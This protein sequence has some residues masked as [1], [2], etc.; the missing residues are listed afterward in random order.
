MTEAASILLLGESGVGKTHYGAQLLKRLMLSDG[1]LRMHGQATNLEPF[2][3]ALDSLSEGRAAGHT[4]TATYLDSVWPV[5][6]SQGHA[7]ELVWPDYGGEQIKALIDSRCVPAAWQVR[8]ASAD[9]WLLLI[10]LQ[11]TRSGDDIFS[12]PLADLRGAS[13]ENK[14][15]QMSDQARLIELLQ[16]LSYAGG[17]SAT[18]IA[19]RPRFAVLLTCW[20]EL[21]L[22]GTPVSALGAHLPM[23][24]DYIRSN[25]SEPCVM[26]LSALG[27]PLSSTERDDDY[28]SRGPEH[29]GYV[30]GPDGSRSSDLTLPISLVING[31]S[32]AGSRT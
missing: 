30:I 16:M 15:V 25:W 17:I 28:V 9:A 27:R 13:I 26:A 4:A 12:R 22:T 10:R 32:T 23:L 29:F 1:H 31:P 19:E 8:V 7:A 21:G 6:D 18:P 14:Q 11:Q 5:T 24:W 3:A 2:E 20:D